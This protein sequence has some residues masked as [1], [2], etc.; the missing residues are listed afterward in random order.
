MRFLSFLILLMAIGLPGCSRQPIAGCHVG[1]LESGPKFLH[2]GTFRDSL[3]VVI[4]SDLGAPRNGTAT[5]DAEAWATTDKA[6]YDGSRRTSD[7]RAVRWSAET[8]DGKTGTV[9]VNDKAYQLA[10]GAVFL[11]RTAGG[12]TRVTQVKQ[13]VSG[14]RPDAATWELLGKQN[15]AVKDFLDEVRGK[16]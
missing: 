11:V 7:G 15:A 1:G 2:Y 12:S 6:V 14:L 3:A 9:T 13:D 4:W 5:G 16:K 10:D 8:K